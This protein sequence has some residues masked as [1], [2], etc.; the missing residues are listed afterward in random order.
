MSANRRASRDMVMVLDE[1]FPVGSAERKK[2]IVQLTTDVK[3]ALATINKAAEI[4]ITDLAHGSV[5]VHF[6]FVSDAAGYLEEEY[7][8]QVDDEKSALYEGE[9]TC[10]IDQKRTQ[11]M[12]M[13]LSS[14]CTNEIP[15]PYQPGDTITLAQVQE[16]TI[17]CQVESLLG[18]GATAT[19]FKVTTSGKVCALKVFKAENSFEELCTEASLMLTSNHPDSHPN[20]LRADFVWYEQRTNEMFFLLELIDGSDLQEWM[21]DERLYAGTTEEQKERLNTT[22]HQIACGVR[23]LHERSILHKDIKPENVLMSKEGRPVL[24]DLGVASP[25]TIE[26]GIVKATLQGGTPVYASP[27]VREL[28]FQAKALPVTERK[29]F[30]QQHPIT[31]LDDFFALGATILDM[32]AECGWRRGQSVADVLATTSL[33]ELVNDT[34]LMRVAVPKDMVEVLH[35]CFSADDSLTVDSIVELTAKLCTH[36]TPS[37]DEGMSK[38]HFANI[39]NNL[40]VALY[41]SGVQKQEQG[42]NEGAARCFEAASAQLEHAIT[43]NHDDARTLNNLG[44]VKLTQGMKEQ[45]R[46]CFDDAIKADP[47]HAAATS[48]ISLLEGTRQ[49]TATLDR[50]GAAGAVEDSRGKVDLAKAL[51]FAPGQQLEVYRGGK[52][53]QTDASNLNTPLVELTYRLP[54]QLAPDYSPEQPL[55]VHEDD[56]WVCKQAEKTSL[57]LDSTNHAPALF[58]D[59]DAIRRAQQAYT[60]EIKEKHTSILDLFSG[61]KL[62]VRTQTATLEFRAAERAADFEA[63][64]KAQ[65]TGTHAVQATTILDEMLSDEDQ[66]E[67]RLRRYML[68]ILGSAASGKTTLLKTLMMEIVHRCPDL[69][70]ILVPIIEVA[71]VL[72]ACNRDEGES[73]VAAFIQRKY[74]QHAHLLLQMM[75]TRRAVFFIDGIDESG[76]KHQKAVEDFITVELLEPGHKTIITSRHSGFSSRAFEQCKLVEL[77]PLSAEEQAKMVL[78]RIQDNEKA[79]ELVKELGTATFKDI[80]SN[81]LMLSMMVSVYVSNNGIVISNRSELY[82]KALRTIMGRT[83]KGRAGLDQTE[84]AALLAHLQ[85]LAS[86]SHKRAGERRN[87]TAAQ[88]KEWASEE[89]WSAIEGA[90]YQG[91][92]PI[93]NALGLNKNEED[94]YRF[95]HMSYQEYLTACEYY[96]QLTDTNFSADEVRRCFGQELRHAFAEV[97]HHLML[98]LLA[99]TRLQTLVLSKTKLGADDDGIRILTEALNTNTTLTALDVSENELGADGVAG[100]TELSLVTH[101]DQLQLQISVAS[102]APV[103]HNTLANDEPLD[104]VPASPPLADADITNGAELLG[105]VALV[106][107]GG[108][109]TF[110]DKAKRV[111]AAGALAMLCVND[112]KYK[113]DDVFGMERD[114]LDWEEDMAIPVMMV[115]FNTGRQIQASENKAIVIRKSESLTDAIKNH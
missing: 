30:L 77:L 91:R 82:D 32:F 50:T 75:L 37:T 66:R 27:N 41:D 97:R 88:A 29:D 64:Q 33:T 18:E 48:N 103:P 73:V 85:K 95:G 94:E 61:Q 45:A 16:E 86:A 65:G 14:G 35:A 60:I 36:A 4:D 46:S 70:P 7:L 43:A 93:I 47:G 8:R 107:R 56:K 40:G 12:T 21:D 115:S 74:R 54:S 105:K 17:A 99:D 26:K 104:V 25:G 96:Q 5:I 28:F 3:K 69:V 90:M 23:H 15:C 63:N 112:D 67:V 76:T 98:Q 52:W 51:I 49:G 78:A 79:K 101:F 20:I 22:A 68:L 108:N 13:Q 109:C 89:G 83:D 39:R 84:Q 42:K 72:D 53:E 80:A 62:S 92:L 11:T 106:H 2:L 81:P 102:W 9:V 87:F 6:R 55:L 59:L 114:E 113:P 1:M 58:T 57:R 71:P 38:G 19:V 44:V 100:F 24:A 34:K 110:V 31:H 10:R 111:Q